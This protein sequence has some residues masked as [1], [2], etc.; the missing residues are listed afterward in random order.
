MAF[1]R[2]VKKDV[3]KPSSL[4]IV[5]KILESSLF[6][7]PKKTASPGR[8]GAVNTRDETNHVRR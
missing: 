4:V 3:D 2:A 7:G 1:G 8:G 5:L 6:F